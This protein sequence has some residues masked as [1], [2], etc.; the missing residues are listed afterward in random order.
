MRRGIDPS[1][2]LKGH[3][4][5]RRKK[6]AEARLNCS[7]TK[8]RNRMIEEARKRHFRKAD[9]YAFDAQ[10]APH[11]TTQTSFQDAQ[12]PKPTQYHLPERAVVVRLIQM[13]SDSLAERGKLTRRIRVIEA[14]AALCRR[15]ENRRRR[16]PQSCIKQEQP[17]TSSEDST[18]G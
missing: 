1:E 17:D 7:K 12:G 18:E 4:S 16:P 13:S 14:V 5:L 11:S 2:L 10:F 15:Q 6:K 8:M 9:T 3:F